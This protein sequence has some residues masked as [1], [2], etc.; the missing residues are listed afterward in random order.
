MSGSECELVGLRLFFS[1]ATDGGTG[2]APGGAG[3]GAGGAPPGRG[4]GA[5]FGTAGGL[6]GG[7]L[8]LEF[9]SG[10]ESYILTP[11]ALFRSLGIPPANKPPN[12]GAC[13]IPPAAALV[14]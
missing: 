7:G 11:P 10:S 5:P 12:C 6:E 1:A 8:F 9:V 2:A 4:G 3:G 14:A 13:S